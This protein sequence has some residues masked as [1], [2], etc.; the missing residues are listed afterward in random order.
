MYITP[1][2]MLRKRMMVS[3]LLRCG[4]VSP[5]T[6]VTLQQAGIFPGLFYALPNIL[7]R[8]GVLGMTPDGRYFVLRYY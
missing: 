2:L 1:V 3:R 7:M 8:R 4:A 5:Q 6:A